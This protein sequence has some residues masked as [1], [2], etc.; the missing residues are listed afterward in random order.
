M[1]EVK[2]KSKMISFSSNMAAS[3]IKEEI[4]DD[5]IIGF[6]TLD[7]KETFDLESQ[8][9]GPI[10]VEAIYEKSELAENFNRASLALV[11]ADSISANIAEIGL[12]EEGFFCKFKAKK[13]LSQNDFK[14]IEKE[15][16]KKVKQSLEFEKNR[17]SYEESMELNV[18]FAEKL[19]NQDS[20]NSW[21]K[22]GKFQFPFSLP[23]FKT[24]KQC[25]TH[26]KLEKIAGELFNGEEVQ[27]I[28]ASAFIEK[29]SLDNHLENLEK[30][31]KNDHR[32]LGKNMELFH[33]TPESPGSVFWLK[34]GWQLYRLLQEYMR[35]KSYHN[36]EEVKTPFVMSSEFWKKSGHMEAFKQN[37]MFVNMGHGAEKEEAALKPM[38]CPAHIE[39]FKSKQRSYKDLPVRLA[40]FGSC[41][42]YEP[43]GA[44]HGLM[45][46]RSFTQD[47][48]HIFCMESQIKEEVKVFM[49]QALSIY[50]SFG[51]KDIKTIIST[52]PDNF[53]G[54]VDKW[55]FAEDQLK[56]ALE[57]SKLSYEIAEGEGAFYGPKIEIQ[58]KDS[59]KR[60]WQLGTIQ[61]DFVLPERLD[62]SYTNE[63]DEKARPC[64]L[65]RAIFGSIERFIGVLL[66]SLEGKLPTWLAPTQAAICS[67]SENFNEYS[68]KVYEILKEKGLRVLLDNRN[69]KLGYK[70]REHKVSKTPVLII[71]G[72]NEEE[73]QTVTVE[74]N[75]KQTF[76]INEL[77]KLVE[78]LNAR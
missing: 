8:I 54:E 78:N 28:T 65:H 61:L 59:L 70:I 40:E 36:Y 11:L 47:D 32:E 25:S 62:V 68:N 9:Q 71:I 52:R 21:C 23:T 72:K 10:K 27:K 53:L 57:E 29:E 26:F 6:I 22:V 49:A 46:V 20:P 18:C 37:M 24:T 7:K 17:L 14:E 5:S 63:K 42:R 75:E 15:M 35:E 39:I 77:D 56:S 69:Q 60:S 45:R 44:L 30:A 4:K 66:E 73:T 1:I 48:G 34:N 31:A 51:F 74:T 38:N 16:L 19:L 50:K 64:M 12:N 13:N 3:Q 33:I 43:S 2:S 58:V 41:H 76:S 67:V 55:N